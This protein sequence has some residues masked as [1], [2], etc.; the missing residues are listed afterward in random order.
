MFKHQCFL[1]K[2]SVQTTVQTPPAEKAIKQPQIE[3]STLN[4]MCVCVCV[5]THSGHNLSQIKH[6]NWRWMWK[7]TSCFVG[8]KAIWVHSE[9][10][11]HLRGVDFN[12][13]SSGAR[14]YVSQL[15][16]Y[17]VCAKLFRNRL[18]LRTL[19]GN[20]KQRKHG[21]GLKAAAELQIQ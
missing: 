1:E 5:F 2:Q 20:R 3:H 6:E 13:R 8:T 9:F 16:K 11:K 4:P 15:Y 19:A 18:K 14:L 21:T 7:N 12:E 17:H 10:L